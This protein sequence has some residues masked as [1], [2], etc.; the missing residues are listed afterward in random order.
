MQKHFAV[1][2]HSLIFNESELLTRKFIVL[3]DEDGDICNF[4]DFHRYIRSSSKQYARKITDDGNSRHYYV[5]KLLNYVFFDKYHIA[6]LNDLTIEMV[7]SF[8]NDY[9]KGLLPSDTRERTKSTV[10]I[11]IRTIIDFLEEYI[12]KNN[13][14]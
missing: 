4:T 14:T 1:Y 12:K 11:C 7:S 9:G 13:Q 5:V 6:K 10:S 2:E 3:K 8:L